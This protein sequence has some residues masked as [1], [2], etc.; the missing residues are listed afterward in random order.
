MAESHQSVQ[1]SQFE[2]VLDRCLIVCSANA[3]KQLKAIAIPT[4]PSVGTGKKIAAK[5]ALPDCCIC[6]CRRFCQS[7][8]LIDPL[9][10]THRPVQCHDP[11]SLVHRSLFTCVPLQ[12]HTSAPRDPS[13]RILL[14]FMQDVRR[15]RG[16]CRG[17]GRPRTRRQL[18]RRNFCSLCGGYRSYCSWRSPKYRRCEQSGTRSRRGC[19]D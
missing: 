18:Y 7:I 8:L 17:R 19:G 15:S 1:V 11:P 16:G 13:S 10:C 9:R 6:A 3:L 14:S 5:S 2:L 12:V 4:A